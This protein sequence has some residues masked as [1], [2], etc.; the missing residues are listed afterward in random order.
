MSGPT[1]RATTDRDELPS[2]TAKRQAVRSMFD[3]IAGRYEL[4]NRIMTLGLDGRWRRR[5]VQA[6]NLPA[7]S[8]ILDCACGTADF[9]R[10][11]ADRGHVAIGLDL[12][13]GMLGA[14]RGSAPLVCA[15]IVDMPVPDRAA[16]GATCGFALRNLVEIEPFLHE[17]ARVVRPGG[18]IALLEVGQPSHRWWGRGHRF[19]LNQVVPRIGSLLS[20]RTAYRYL[21]QSLAYLPAPEELSAGLRAVGFHRVAHYRLTGGG[22]Q[23]FTATRQ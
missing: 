18:R 1:A 8:M 5:T 17:L 2:K 10:Q 4:L 20:D 15:D 7:G 16:D 3:A 21:P 12:S 23:L 13:V 9:C 11:L 6:L 22:A 14:A 19:Y